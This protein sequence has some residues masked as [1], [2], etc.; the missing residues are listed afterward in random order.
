VSL[1]DA[2][3]GCLS[4][5]STSR[6]LLDAERLALAKLFAAQA[7]TAMR[8]AQP[9]TELV[10]ALQTSRTI[11]NAGGV[12]MERFDI[13]DQQAFAYLAR[14][15]QTTNVKLRDV[16]AHLVKQSNKQRHL[17]RS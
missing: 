8:Q 17:P 2:T 4:L 5:Y 1:D 11:G 12:V 16:A 13:D 15:S 14:L 6:R 7:A 3:I 10:R 9:E